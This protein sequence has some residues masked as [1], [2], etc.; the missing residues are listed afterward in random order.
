MRHASIRAARKL[1]II[2][3]D[4]SMAS[5]RPPRSHRASLDRRGCHPSIRVASRRAT[6]LP[7]E[8]ILPPVSGYPRQLRDLHGP[9]AKMAPSSDDLTI[10]H[11]MAPDR[12]SVK[13]ACAQRSF[14]PRSKMPAF[15]CKASGI[16]ATEPKKRSPRTGPGDRLRAGGAKGG[17]KGTWASR[18]RAGNSNGMACHRRWTACVNR[19]RYAGGRQKTRGRSR[20]PESGTSGSVRGRGATRVYRERHKA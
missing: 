9:D 17:N 18:A 3:G 16:A 7:S 15:A 11:S 20:V 10:G 5:G 4:R 19:R 14:S 12:S 1:D 6:E 13:S 8:T 2:A